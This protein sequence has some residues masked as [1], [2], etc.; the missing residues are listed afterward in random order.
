MLPPTS[1]G[2]PTGRSVAGRLG[3][4]VTEGPGGALSMHQQLSRSPCDPMDFDLQVLC[5]TSNNRRRSPLGRSVRKRTAQMT[6]D[7]TIGERAVDRGT[8]EPR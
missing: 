3:W 6:E 2:W 1:T 5:E 4:P 8:Q 7:L